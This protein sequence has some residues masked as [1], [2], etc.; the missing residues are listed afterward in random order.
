M[1]WQIGIFS[2]IKRASRKSFR[3]K[4]YNNKQLQFFFE[5]VS[6]QVRSVNVAT[7]VSRCFSSNQR[8]LR[9]LI[10]YFIRVLCLFVELNGICCFMEEGEKLHF[11][12]QNGKSAKELSV[13]VWRLLLKVAHERAPLGSEGIMEDWDH[14]FKAIAVHTRKWIISCNIHASQ[15]HV[16]I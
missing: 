6:L 2:G 8:F 4:L 11:H 3:V 15:G 9:V 5:K 14:G 13:N 10:I 16:A 1:I 12:W 7:E